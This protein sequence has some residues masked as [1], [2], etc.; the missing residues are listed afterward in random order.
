[1]FHGMDHPDILIDGYRG[2]TCLFLSLCT[3]GRGR[4]SGDRG[5]WFGSPPSTYG[6]DDA[7]VLSGWRSVVRD[8]DLSRITDQQTG[9]TDPGY[10]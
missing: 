4:D 3:R 10:S 5:G 9:I 1:M 8:L 7:S 2:H 6:D